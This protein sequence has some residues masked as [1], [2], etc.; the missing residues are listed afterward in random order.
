MALTKEQFQQ[1]RDA[2]YSV[3]QIVGFEKKRTGEVQQEELPTPQEGNQPSPIK[4]TLGSILEDYAMQQSLVP[5]SM[6]EIGALLTG[7]ATPEAGVGLEMAA[8]TAKG[9]AFPPAMGFGSQMMV[10]KPLTAGTA[11]GA[12]VP[13]GKAAIAGGLGL[14]TAVGT[15]LRK[16]GGQ[17]FLNSMIANANKEEG[18]TGV[19]PLTNI[20]SKSGRDFLGSQTPQ[21][22]LKGIEIASEVL[23]GMGTA[24][25]NETMNALKPLTKDISSVVN[26]FFFKAVKPSS[27]KV[28]TIGG[29]KKAQ[30]NATTTI[31]TI[32]DDIDNISFVDETGQA[33]KKLPETL[34]EFSSA[35]KQTMKKLFVEYDGLAKEAGGTGA[36]ISLDDVADDLIE[37]AKRVDVDVVNPGAKDYATKLAKRIR[38]RKFSLP[39]AQDI[40]EAFNQKLKTFYMNPLADDA[41]QSVFDA[42]VNN[43]VRQKLSDV[44]ENTTGGDFS[45]L[46]AKYGALRSVEESVS[47]AAFRDATKG[48]ATLLDMS[49]IFTVSDMVTGLAFMQPSRFIRGGAGYLLKKVQ[50]TLSNPNG[51]VK[52]MFKRSMQ[53]KNHAKTATLRNLLSIK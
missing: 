11:I 49:N 29:I 46:K 42:M 48:G 53:I 52:S 24:V 3:D 16:P 21:T 38:G 14:R 26:K 28:K 5:E 23:G 27:A 4:E 36:T 25:I 10:E 33:V 30:S 22:L 17:E 43:R 50:Q 31:N 47:K 41:S 44:V 39:E 15:A 20:A 7:Q 9:M 45:G 40:V 13:G 18:A 6:S 51:M 19:N 1:A 34:E 8:N 35:I 37:M 12:G 32:L 2:G